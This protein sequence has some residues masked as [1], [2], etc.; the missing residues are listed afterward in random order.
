MLIVLKRHPIKQGLKWKV[1]CCCG[2]NLWDVYKYK[3]YASHS[4]FLLFLKEIIGD[5]LKERAYFLYVFYKKIRRMPLTEHFTIFVNLRLA[6]CQNCGFGIVMQK[7]PENLLRKYYQ[8]EYYLMGAVSD[9]PYDFK[10]D[11]RVKGQYDFIKSFV[12]PKKILE[13][14]AGR[15][16]LSQ[17]LKFVYP[18][19]QIDV[20]EPAVSLKDYYNSLGFNLIAKYF[21]SLNNNETYDYIHTSHWLEHI[22]NPEVIFKRLRELLKDSGFLFI[23]V[24]YCSQEYYKLRLTDK[25]HLTFWTKESIKN[26]LQKNGFRIISCQSFGPTFMGNIQGELFNKFNQFNKSGVFLRVLARKV[27]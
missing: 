16:G 11:K 6:R 23:E 20:I 14:G 18:N 25:P 24:P 9:K 22:Q 17:F 21:F 7:I 15:A 3:E 12:R 8:S 27:D 4:D 2:A 5:F 10:Q 1:C 26:I 13:I 19:V